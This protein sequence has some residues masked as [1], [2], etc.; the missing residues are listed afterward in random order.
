M[1][2]STKVFSETEV[3]QIGIR[4]AG[5]SQTRMN[6]CVGTWEE[7][8]ET[9]TMTKK[10]RGVVVKTRTKGTGKGKIKATLHAPQDIL[11]KLR[12]MEVKGLKDGVIAY[13]TSSLHPVFSV[14]AKV[15]D[16]DDNVKFKAYPTC[17]ITSAL[18]RKVENGNEEV[19]EIE[20]EIDI[21]PDENG[22]GLYEALESDLTDENIK[23]QWLENFSLDMIK[24]QVL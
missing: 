8:L 2:I 15:L 12:G 13:G 4:F 5:E 7:E 6:S 14:T 1:S 16:E 11:A 23:R 19:A 22:N 24:S 18:T 20:L 10:C 3:R 21:N 17:T 9:R